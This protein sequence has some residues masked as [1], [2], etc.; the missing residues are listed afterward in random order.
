[1]RVV[2]G[3][4]VGRKGKVVELGFLGVLDVPVPWV[5]MREGILAWA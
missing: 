3:V 1:L 4:F 2:G 5:V